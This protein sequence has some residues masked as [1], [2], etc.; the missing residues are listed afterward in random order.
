MTRLEKHSM[1]SVFC[2]LLVF[3]CV[4]L[5]LRFLF[6]LLL[7]VRSFLFYVS[8]LADSIDY[9]QIITYQRQ[10]DDKGSPA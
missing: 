8:N 2:L 6:K 3:I 9:L 5:L 10:D 4:L 1:Y 7:C